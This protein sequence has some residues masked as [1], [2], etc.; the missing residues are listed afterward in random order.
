[1]AVDLSP[2]ERELLARIAHRW[3]LDDR[4]QT[5]IAHEFGLSRPKVQRLL[6]RARQAGVVQIRIDTPLGVDLRLEAQLIEAFGLTDAIVSP[7]DPD[8][9]TQRAAVAR[10]AAGYLAAIQD[11]VN[12]IAES[13]E[14]FPMESHGMR[15][16]KLRDYPYLVHF[17]IVDDRLCRIY[18]V[19]HGR[20]R[21]RFWLRRLRQP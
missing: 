5:E 19:P 9:E 14:S 15:W 1:M 7:S 13:A 18:A 3:Y 11:A 6:A 21:P 12:R 20:R 17:M 16:A 8:P 2:D 10:A 4:T